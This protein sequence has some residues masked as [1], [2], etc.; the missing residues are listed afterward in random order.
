MTSQIF[1]NAVPRNLFIDFI[2]KYADQKKNYYQFSKTSFKK[3]QL[4][5]ND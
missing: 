4:E 1:K 3:A 2:K 5:K